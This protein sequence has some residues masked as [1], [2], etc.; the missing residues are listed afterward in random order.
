[1]DQSSLQQNFFLSSAALQGDSI[2]C[3]EMGDEKN[4]NLEAKAKADKDTVDGQ[5]RLDD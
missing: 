1:M 5:Q 2:N 4:L 3:C